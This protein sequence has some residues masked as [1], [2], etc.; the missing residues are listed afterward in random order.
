MMYR[1]GYIDDEE[2]N[3]NNFKIDSKNQLEVVEIELKEDLNDLL[4]DILEMN[5]DGVIIDHCLNINSSRIHYTGAEILNK[6][7]DELLD[8]PAVVLTAYED[9]AESK[10]EIETFKIYD[11]EIY[12]SNPER[13]IRKLQRQIINYKYNIEKKTEKYYRLC[14][15]DNLSAKEEAEKIELDEYLEKTISIRNKMPYN[16]KFNTNEERLDK[17]I[18]LAKRT[19]EEVEKYVK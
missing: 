8:F 18:N 4:Y 12:N 17:L 2:I 13:F 5:L 14:Q 1:V 16:L 10:E 6:L 3:I 7:E 19:L 11:K 9:E 15:S